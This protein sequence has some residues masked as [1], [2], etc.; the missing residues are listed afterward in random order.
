[1]VQD[2]LKIR[3]RRETRKRWERVSFIR[4][5]GSSRS[6]IVPFYCSHASYARRHQTLASLFVPFIRSSRPL[7]PSSCALARP[8]IIAVLATDSRLATPQLSLNRATRPSRRSHS[9]VA[10]G[11]YRT[12]TMLAGTPPVATPRPLTRAGGRSRPAG[13]PLTP[14]RR[15][16]TAGSGRPQAR[17]LLKRV[18]M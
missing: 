12:R 14:D 16:S 11:S 13:G 6:L 4:T 5:Y 8:Q 15:S 18:E 9:P 17:G 7:S 10:T 2:V 1:M 3:R